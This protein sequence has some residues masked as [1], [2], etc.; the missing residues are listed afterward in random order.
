M[1]E[2]IRI[3]VLCIPLPDNSVLKSQNPE[4]WILT[5]SLLAN[6]PPPQGCC[7]YSLQPWSPAR[8]VQVFCFMSRVEM[9]LR[10]L[11][12]C[13]ACSYINQAAQEA[14]RDNVQLVKSLG[15]LLSPLWELNP[16]YCKQEKLLLFQKAIEPSL[17]DWSDI[18]LKHL[19]YQNFN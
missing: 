17:Q 6:L 3:K 2:M 15:A 18:S 12:E 8:D 13:R 14:A 11:L 19:V 10:R 4:G 16:A 7:A 1:S 9:W 5:C